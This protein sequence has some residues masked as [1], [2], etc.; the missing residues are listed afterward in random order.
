MAEE[1]PEKILTVTVDPMVGLQPFQAR[2]LFF[3]LKLDESQMR[4]FTNLMSGLYQ[5][6]VEK[7]LALLEINPL[8]VTKENKIIWAKPIKL[9]RHK[10]NKNIYEIKTRT[11]REVWRRN[12]CKV[13]V[14]S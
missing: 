2:E 3:A 9:I 4:E 8:V 5:M 11:G 10:V 1:H 14:C 12:S 6:F 7:D 13:W